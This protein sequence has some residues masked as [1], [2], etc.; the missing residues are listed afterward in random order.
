MSNWHDSDSLA[1]TKKPY[2][3]DDSFFYHI[4][5]SHPQY[6][7][8]E[9]FTG[10]QGPPVQPMSHHHS[11]VFD[12]RD[13]GYPHY[14]HH[15][16]GGHY[17]NPHHSSLKRRSLAAPP[18]GVGQRPMFVHDSSSYA[19]QP[20]DGGSAALASRDAKLLNQVCSYCSLAHFFLSLNSIK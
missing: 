19:R 9:W 2:N 20:I 6:I 11:A 3:M 17:P 16:G 5:G 1:Q 14:P 7:S 13:M 12:P 15:P 8:E 18:G 4:S 10:N